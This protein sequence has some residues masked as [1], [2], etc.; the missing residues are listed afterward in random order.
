MRSD[1]IIKHG[2]YWSFGWL[3]RSEHD[4]KGLFCFESPDGELWLARNRAI[5]LD[6][7]RDI[8]TGELYTCPAP[9]PRKQMT[10]VPPTESPS[11]SRDA[12]G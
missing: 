4:E 6:C 9:L 10:Y 8:K 1:P 5:Y 3:R 12:K 11:A 2:W 7:R